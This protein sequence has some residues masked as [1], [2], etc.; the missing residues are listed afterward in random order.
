MD[1]CTPYCEE[2]HFLC[3]AGFGKRTA[4]QLAD[5]IYN[6]EQTVICKTAAHTEPSSTVPVDV[7]VRK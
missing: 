5:M 3:Y 2:H 1:D 7:Q 6:A 4:D